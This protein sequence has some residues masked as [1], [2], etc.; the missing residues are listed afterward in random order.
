MSNLLALLHPEE[1]AFNQITYEM[2]KGIKRG[3]IIKLNKDF[4]L[5]CY[6]YGYTVG[7]DEDEDEDEEPK[8]IV[9][10][11]EEEEVYCVMTNGIDKIIFEAL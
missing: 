11:K 7:T 5:Y 2:V 4:K 10:L 8:H 9:L 6:E 3:Q 1:N